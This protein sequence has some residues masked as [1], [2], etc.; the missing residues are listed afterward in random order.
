MSRPAIL[1]LA[2]VAACFAAPR[3][4]KVPVWVEASQ[5]AAISAGDLSATL[6]GNSLRVLGIKGPADD[7]IVMVVLDL[8]GDLAYTEPAKEALI[9]AIQALPAN[10]W[11]SLLRAQD[12]LHVILDPTPDREAVTAAVRSLSVS[13]KAGLLD[14]IET[15]G[16]VADTI[17]S[18]TSVRSAVLYLTDS[19]VQNYREDFTNPV[20]NSS[21][22]HDLSRK[23]PEALIQ[24]KVSKVASALAGRQAPLFIV[25]V[26]YRTDRLNEAYQNGL[27]QIAEVTGGSAALCRSDAEIPEAVRRSLALISAHYSVTLALPEHPSRNVLVM[28]ESGGGQS[29]SYRSRFVLN[30]K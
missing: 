18:K 11:V 12:G 26:H 17:L 29:L 24:E 30:E 1:A 25:H 21:D 10:A 6:G 16:R 20:I 28:I 7:L 4:I 23:F 14:T 19:D 5:G 22:Q 13:G 2:C 3:Q 27:R 15:A 8:T 9:E